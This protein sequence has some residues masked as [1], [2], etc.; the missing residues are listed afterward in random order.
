VINIKIVEIRLEPVSLDDP[1]ERDAIRSQL[2]AIKFKLPI[3]GS[4]KLTVGE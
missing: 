1:V 4:R 2:E 3:L